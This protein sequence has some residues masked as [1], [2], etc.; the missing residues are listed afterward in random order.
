MSV[1]QVIEG[2]IY[3]KVYLHMTYSYKRTFVEQLNFHI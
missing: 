2:R 1:G 3:T